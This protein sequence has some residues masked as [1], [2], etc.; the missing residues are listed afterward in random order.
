MRIVATSGYFNPFHMGHLALLRA[1]REEFPDAKI[2][3]I[4][5]NDHQVEL[6]KSKKFQNE[7]ERLEL[8]RSNRYVDDAILS[9]DTDRTV[10]RTIQ[11]IHPNV[12]VKGGD[13]IPEN[14]PELAW[15]IANGTQVVF[16]VGGAK[17][18]SSSWLKE[19]VRA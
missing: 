3:V 5:N 12:F 4:V 9:I 6:K 13:S 17:I 1:A 14:T 8:V 19:G 16:E 7:L 18:Q 11:Q 10:L 15:C 2:V